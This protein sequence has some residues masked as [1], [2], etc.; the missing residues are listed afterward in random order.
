MTDSGGGELTV[1]GI[2]SD[3]AFDP[4]CLFSLKEVKKAYFDC[5][6]L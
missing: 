5:L 3:S 4:T 6:Q 2:L 1:V